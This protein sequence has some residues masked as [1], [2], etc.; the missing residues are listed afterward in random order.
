[1]TEVQEI[2]DKLRSFTKDELID[3]LIGAL[4]RGAE[5]A[6]RLAAQADAPTID[7]IPSCGQENDYRRALPQS[8]PDET[9]RLKAAM[10]YACDLLAE[11]TYGSPAR[12]PGHNARLHLEAALSVTRPLR[13]GK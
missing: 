11:R 4:V 12:S 9:L 7:N 3:E 13:E 5:M 8:P 10:D 6:E 1:M 2:K